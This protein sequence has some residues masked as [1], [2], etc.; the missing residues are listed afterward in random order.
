MEQGREQLSAVQEVKLSYNLPVRAIA[1]L[2]DLLAYLQGRPE[3]AQNLLK[4][5]A[6]RNQ[7]GAR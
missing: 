7:F 6:Y 2:D 3:L 1:S 5:Q 4:I